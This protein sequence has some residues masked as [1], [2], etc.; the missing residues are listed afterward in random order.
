M[1]PNKLLY[2]V[3]KITNLIN[4]KIYIGCHV[5]KNVN[6]TY[7]GSGKLIIGAIKK[8]GIE[9]FKKEILFYCDDKESMLLK[10]KEI[11]NKEFI[12]R[13]DTYNLII[14]GTLNMSEFKHNKS[15]RPSVAG[16]NNP[17][18]GKKHTEKTK[19]LMSENGKNKFSTEIIKKL[20]DYQKNNISCIERRKL[21]SE[22]RKGIQLKQE[23]KNKISA[24]NKNKIVS[25]ETKKK[26]SDSA[27]GENN[28]F[29]NK[30]HTDETRKK[31][32]IA[33]KNRIITESHCKKISESRKGKCFAYD[34]LN[35]RMFVLKNDPRFITG[36]LVKKTK[37]QVTPVETNWIQ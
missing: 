13:E 33:R 21:I 23:T 22:N 19:K 1:K 7:Y 31:M 27:A 20:S 17:M 34:K 10:E 37:E 28:P 26:M 30:T 4:N 2:L 16:K 32:S 29:Y 8:Y 15:N 18:Y 14:G 11:V 36:E 35:N 9:N 25:N 5:T 12:L 6:D 24:F 3:Y